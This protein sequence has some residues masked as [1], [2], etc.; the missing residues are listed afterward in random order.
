MFYDIVVDY[1]TGPAGHSISDCIFEDA[2]VGMGDSLRSEDDWSRSGGNSSAVPKRYLLDVRG[3]AR[4][5]KWRP[6]LVPALALRRI[7]SRIRD[8]NQ[9]RRSEFTDGSPRDAKTRCDD[10]E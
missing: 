1:R 6:H 3:G 7:K 4:R 10:P 2:P 9:L 8:G 5:R